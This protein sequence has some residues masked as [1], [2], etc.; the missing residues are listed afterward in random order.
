MLPNKQTNNV[1]ANS[2]VPFF[3]VCFFDGLVFSI[4]FSFNELDT[5]SLNTLSM[6]E[7]S[8]I[9]GSIFIF[10]CKFILFYY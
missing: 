5:V 2:P 4:D 6:Y 3:F 7:V 9:L 1:K 8:G 10:K